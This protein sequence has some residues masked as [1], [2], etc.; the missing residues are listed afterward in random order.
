[1]EAARSPGKK[2]VRENA[3][4]LRSRM[5]PENVSGG[6]VPKGPANPIRARNWQVHR[7]GKRDRDDLP[8]KGSLR[9][10]NDLHLSRGEALPSLRRQ[11]NECSRQQGY[12]A[13]AREGDL[14]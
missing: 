5:D 9:S 7:L 4:D 2:A 6:A 1:M 12:Q 8:H 11:S 10:A 13:L 3:C 14:T